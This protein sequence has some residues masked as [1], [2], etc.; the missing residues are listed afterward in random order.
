MACTIIHWA[1][2]SSCHTTGIARWSERISILVIG[3]AFFDNVGVIFICTFFSIV[4]YVGTQE[5]YFRCADKRKVVAISTL[6]LK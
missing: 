6:T 1:S 3:I 5:K 4:S 2:N